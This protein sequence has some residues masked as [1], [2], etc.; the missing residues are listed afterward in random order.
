MYALR[1]IAARRAPFAAV[2]QRAAFSSSRVLLAGKE[3]KLRMST[4]ARCLRGRANKP[5]TEGRADEAEEL[6][7][8]QLNNQKEGKG[9][10]EEG[11]ASDSE[12]IVRINPALV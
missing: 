3:S 8:K 2:S 1:T 10:W 12:S 4:T 7:Q 5:D 9:K 6:K 11:L